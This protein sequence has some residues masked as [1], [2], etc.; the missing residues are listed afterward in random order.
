MLAGSPISWKSKNQAMVS[1][2]SLEAEYRALVAASSEITWMVRLLV[3]FGI[4]KL[5]HV[6]LH[7]DNQSAIH[8]AYNPVLH[9]RTKHIEVD[10][11]FTHDKVLEGLIQ[12]TY[13]PSSSQLADVLTK[14]LPSNQFHRL[15]LTA[16]LTSSR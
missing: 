8:I 10:C 3:E 4:T 7:C 16:N 11:H 1:R 9:E 13:L 5:Q 2:S 6:T 15:L 12:L 14:I